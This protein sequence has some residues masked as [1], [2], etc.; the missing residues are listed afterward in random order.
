MERK[1]V[2]KRTDMMKTVKSKYEGVIFDGN[3]EMKI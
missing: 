2:Q 3:H 1:K